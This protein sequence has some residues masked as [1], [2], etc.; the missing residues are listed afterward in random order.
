MKIAGYLKT[1][2]LDWPGKVASVIFTVGCNFRCPFCHNRD[3]V[4][5]TQKLELVDEGSLL[6]DL[7][8]RKKWIDGL[9]I[10]G[11]EPTLQPDLAAFCRKVKKLGLGIKLDTNGSH[12]E[13][14]EK[15][16]KNDLV[17]FMAM[18]VKTDINHYSQLVN[19]QE[20]VMAGENGLKEQIKKSIRL[21]V[22][23]GLTYE[24]RTTVVP[25]IHNLESLTKMVAEVG[26]LGVPKL[27]WQN[28]VG[29]NCID[30]KLN[31]KTGYP[32]KIT[33]A[34]K[35]EV[36]RMGVVVNLRGW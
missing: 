11:G 31:G 22:G 9:V 15:L 21:I 30:K 25:E 16:F 19:P 35:K 36:E 1:S 26:K 28:F 27:T 34:W 24:F 14:L 32:K 29:R 18:D 20:K 17:D 3:L 23:S 5:G 4:V 33:L 7:K 12:P 13:V 6:S 10:T 8:K 2:L